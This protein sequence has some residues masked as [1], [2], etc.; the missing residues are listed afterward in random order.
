MKLIATH[1]PFMVALSPPCTMYSH[2]Q[3]LN[4]KRGSTEWELQKR[5]AGELLKFSMDVAKV[6]V[7]SGRYF[8]FEHPMRATSWSETCV[9]EV[10]T[11]P[12]VGAVGLDMRAFGLKAFDQH[13]E[14]AAQERTRLLSNMPSILQEWT[15]NAR[16]T[17]DTSF[18]LTVGRVRQQPTQN[19][20]AIRW[21][22]AWN[23]RGSRM[24]RRTTSSST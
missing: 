11:L 18:W 24:K 7:A 20:F 14:G 17:T 15:D 9:Q 22:S 5:K 1:K 4:K 21:S 23:F 2:L 13:G 16:A 12:G 19:R 6:Q 8:M 10:A 3:S